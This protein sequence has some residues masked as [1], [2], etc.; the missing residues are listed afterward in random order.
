MATRSPSRR[1]FSLTRSPLTREPLLEL[2]SRMMYCVPRYSMTACR[3]ETM[4]SGRTT[5]LLGSRPM[6]SSARASGI[7]RRADDVGLTMS[8]AIIRS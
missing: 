2:Q 7:S 8:L 1:P 5:S 4:A 3:R 6:D